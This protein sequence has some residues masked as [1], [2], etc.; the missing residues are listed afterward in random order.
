MA[1]DP[2]AD[3]GIYDTAFREFE[4]GLDADPADHSVFSDPPR[5]RRGDRCPG[6][7]VICASVDVEHL[8]ACQYQG[9]NAAVLTDA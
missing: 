8:D 7:G 4:A 6:C 5:V 2:D 1:Y 9:R 3:R